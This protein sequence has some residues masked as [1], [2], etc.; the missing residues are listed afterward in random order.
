[1]FDRHGA[2]TWAAT[3]DEARAAL[4]AR[5]TRETAEKPEAS[6]FVFAYTNA[7]VDALNADLRAARLD[8]GELGR[9]H[10][11][12]TAHGELMFAVGDR[13]QFT[14]TRKALRIYSGNVGTI[15]GIDGISGRITAV[16]DGDQREVS[17]TAGELSGFRHG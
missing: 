4:V 3:Q 7:D 16:I 15:T 9:D 8:R 13:V 6:C 1:V 14:Q 12:A 17:W 10:G 2:I 5:W 11:L